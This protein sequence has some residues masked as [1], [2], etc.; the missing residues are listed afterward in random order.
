MWLSTAEWC[1]FKSWLEKNM[2]IAMDPM[3]VIKGGCSVCLWEGAWLQT[4]RVLCMA[5]QEGQKSGPVVTHK[6]E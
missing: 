3:S 5:C 4:C 1:H 2:P 6:L